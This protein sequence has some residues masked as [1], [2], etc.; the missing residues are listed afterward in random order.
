MAE[1]LEKGIVIKKEKPNLVDGRS[2]KS[3][4]RKERDMEDDISDEGEW[5]TTEYNITATVRT[6]EGG[7]ENRGQNKEGRDEDKREM[8]TTRM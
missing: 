1:R 4:R 3:N 7:Q 2:S 8:R 6:E 5:G